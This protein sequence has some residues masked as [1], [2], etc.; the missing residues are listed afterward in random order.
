MLL[1]SLF[2]LSVTLSSAAS[3]AYAGAAMLLGNTPPWVFVLFALLVL[4]GAL[5]LRPRTVGLR[6]S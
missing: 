2:L 4:I 3:P 1:I 6:A 5:G